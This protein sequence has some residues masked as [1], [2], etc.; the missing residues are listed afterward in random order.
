[1]SRHSIHTRRAVQSVST[2]L[3][4]VLFTACQSD[5]IAG[6]ITEC[7]G[8]PGCPTAASTVTP[9]VMQALDDASVRLTSAL[10]AKGRISLEA[11]LSKLESALVAR[12][13][14]AGRLAM[15]GVLSVIGEMEIAS[16]ESRPD[17]TALRLGL[18]PAARTLGLAVSVMEAPAY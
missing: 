9:E 5:Q 10:A 14:S 6:T 12:D 4:S 3:L 15:L 16:P 13:L 2:L 11:A 17:L 8:E 7:N 18:V 1:M